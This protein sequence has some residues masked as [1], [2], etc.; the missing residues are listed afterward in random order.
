MLTLAACTPNGNG[1]QNATQNGNTTVQANQTTA[2][3][4]FDEVSLD[5][6]VNV[7]YQPGDSFTYRVEGQSAALGQLAI[8][9]ADHTLHIGNKNAQASDMA[10]NDSVTVYVTSPSLEEFELAGAGNFTAA[11]PLNATDFHIEL[12]GAGNI[13]IAQLTC[14]DL[15]VEVTGTGNITL[16]M[17]KAI[18]VDTEITGSGNVTYSNITAQRGESQISGSGT[19]SLSGHIDNHI[20][21]VTG[22]GVVDTKGLK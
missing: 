18:E 15:D 21:Q 4:P 16:G 6:A 17:V 19:I 13:N 14:N 8:Y 5:G 22:S 9:V 7:V 20:Q 1:N 11:Q 2:T 3:N 12:A 10:V